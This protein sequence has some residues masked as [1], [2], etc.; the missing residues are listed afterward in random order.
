MTKNRN[1]QETAKPED[2]ASTGMRRFGTLAL[3]GLQVRLELLAVEFEAMRLRLASGVLNLVLA[4][5]LGLMALALLITAVLLA[6][7]EAWRWMAAGGLGA[8]LLAVAAVFVM[9]A[10]R[11]F[12]ANANAFAASLAELRRD[13]EVL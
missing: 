4:F 13:R 12:A 6:V 7:P 8:G 10:R 2:E 9:A 5:G 1:P 11:D 3:E